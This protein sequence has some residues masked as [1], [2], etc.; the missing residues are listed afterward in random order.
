MCCWPFYGLSLK[1]KSLPLHP[2]LPTP[3]C[4]DDTERLCASLDAASLSSLSDAATAEGADAD[5]RRALLA[6]ALARLELR[7]AEEAADREAKKREAEVAL[8]VCVCMSP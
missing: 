5:E 2:Y 4:T 3:L 1:P 7:E 6:A 8:K